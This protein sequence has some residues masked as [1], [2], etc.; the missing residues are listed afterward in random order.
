M[1]EA[2]RATL[3]LGQA[4]SPTELPHD[5]LAWFLGLRTIG[6]LR[7]LRTGPQEPAYGSSVRGGWDHLPSH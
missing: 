5:S 2:G 4:Q 7:G 6:W 1:Q 3:S